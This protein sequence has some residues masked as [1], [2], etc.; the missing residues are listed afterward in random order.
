M[1]TRHGDGDL[2]AFVHFGL[3]C[4]SIRAV[5]AFSPRISVF[6][7]AG[8]FAKIPWPQFAQFSCTLITLLTER[9]CVCLRLLDTLAT[10]CQDTAGPRTAGNPPY[11]STT[12]ASLDTHCQFRPL[13]DHPNA[14]RGQA[15]TR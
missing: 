4:T 9:K 2:D 12:K 11:P 3:R 5:S 1:K 7:T 13:A 6:I 14:T 15:Q 10:K 8:A